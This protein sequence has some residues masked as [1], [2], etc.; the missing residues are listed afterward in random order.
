MHAGCKAAAQGRW[1]RLCVGEAHRRRDRDEHGLRRGSA[2][3]WARPPG[4]L[5]AVLQPRRQVGTEAPADASAAG[6]AIHV[7]NAHVALGARAAGI[8][9]DLELGDKRRRQGRSLIKSLLG[10]LAWRTGPAKLR[11]RRPFLATA[12]PTLRLPLAHLAQRLRPL[13]ALLH[14][15]RRK[16]VDVEGALGAAAGVPAVLAAGDSQLGK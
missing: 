3:G 2:G 10:W 9:I 12:G 15:A 1:A 14:S 7:R 6:G 16:G 11:P 4:H 8:H 13:V 5:V